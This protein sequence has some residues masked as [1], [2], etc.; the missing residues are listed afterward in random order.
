MFYNRH[1]DFFKIINLCLDPRHIGV[2]HI[3]IV[4]NF[5]FMDIHENTITVSGL[6]QGSVPRLSFV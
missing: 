3:K 5:D 2:V 4:L 1:Q 6:V